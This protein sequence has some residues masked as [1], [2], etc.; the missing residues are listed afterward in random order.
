ML[1]KKGY[2]I[3]GESSQSCYGYSLTDTASMKDRADASEIEELNRELLS[4][5]SLDHSNL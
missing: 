1:L 5:V 3:R 4:S 2:H